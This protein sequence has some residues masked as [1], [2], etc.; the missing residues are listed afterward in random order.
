MD[1]NQILQQAQSI[2]FDVNA[3][4]S[5]A[6]ADPAFNRT[7]FFNELGNW[8][9]TQAPSNTQPYVDPSLLPQDDPQTV[10]TQLASQLGFDINAAYADASQDPN[11]N[12]D[13]FFGE[14]SNYLGQKVSGNIQTQ[15]AYDEIAKDLGGAGMAAVGFSKSGQDLITGAKQIGANLFGTPE[16]AAAINA[17]VRDEQQRYKQL[18]DRSYAPF[19]WGINRRIN[20]RFS[21]R[22][23]SCWENNSDTSANRCWAWC[24]S[25][26]NAANGQ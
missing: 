22:R 15:Q 7:A 13:Q 26:V 25:I 12:Q 8:L 20:A 19:S 5:D 3:A 1:E 2:G 6:Q 16:Q 14:L 18:T 24:C 23:Y 4:L 21:N 9:G 11:F 10:A 17:Q